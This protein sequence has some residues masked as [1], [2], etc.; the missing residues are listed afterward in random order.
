MR[1]QLRTLCGLAAAA[2]MASAHAVEAVKLSARQELCIDCQTPIIAN[3][4]WENGVLNNG[5]YYQPSKSGNWM[6]ASSTTGEGQLELRQDPSTSTYYVYNYCASTHGSY[7]ITFLAQVV[8]L[9]AGVEYEFELEYKMTGVRATS[10]FIQM[11]V[12][13][14]ER[15]QIYSEYFFSG[16]TPGD[17][18][19]T[20]KP[21][22]VQLDQSG[23]FILTMAWQNDPNNAEVFIRNVKQV[24]TLCKDP[25]FVSVCP[26]P[27]SSVVPSSSAAPSTS[28][29][30]PSVASSSAVPSSSSA[31]PSSS[32]APSSSR[33]PCR[34]RPRSS[35]V[36][37]GPISSA[38][39]VSSALPTP[40]PQLSAISTI[41]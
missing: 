28:S 19:H 25:E 17:G 36:P 3:P 18:F 13:D 33:L 7:C 24:P 35:S 8:T 26:V 4:G 20:W 34:R 31:I 11:Y 23:D 30:L 5:N 6:L 14:Q 15:N 2:S 38:P 32:A 10:N 22:K 41:N 16:S 21:R 39:S 9:Q 27:S 29:A 40:P 37:S 1:F 12:S